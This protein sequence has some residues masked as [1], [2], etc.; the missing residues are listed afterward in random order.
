M[1]QITKRGRMVALVL[2]AASVVS[3]AATSEVDAISTLSNASAQRTT[4]R[5]V[6]YQVTVTD[7]PGD[8][9][10]TQLTARIYDGRGQIG[11]EI[12]AGS[13]CGGR[14]Y[15]FVDTISTQQQRTVRY[16]ILTARRGA[17]GEAVAVWGR[18]W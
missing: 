18:N 10:C 3:M 14:S 1:K 5:S 4:L 7:T 11:N 15:R 16:V 13:V 17:G 12:V 9:Y 6:A 2:A 8:A